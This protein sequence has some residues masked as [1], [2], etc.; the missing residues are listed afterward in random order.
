MI[1]DSKKHESCRICNSNLLIKYLDLGSTPLANAIVKKEDLSKNE[2]TFPLE[3]VFC[4]KCFL[5][6]LSVVVNPKIMFKEYPYRSS[7]S[8]TFIEHC[9]EIAD[10]CY[11]SYE[12]KGKDLIVDI[13]SND[14]CLLQQFKSKG[15]QVIGVDPATNLAEIATNRGI[16]TINAFWSR[17]VAENIVQENGHAKIIT[18]MNVFAHVND[19]NE[20]VSGVNILLEKEGIFIIEAPH[21]F[22]LIT[23]TEF[24]TIY[25][26]HL[27]YLLIKPLETLFEKYHMN[28]FRVE[29]TPIH[30]GSIRVYVS[31]KNSKHIRDETV[32]AIIGKEQAENLYNINGYEN[33]SKRVENIKR[34]MIDI[35]NKIKIEDKTVA[36]YGASAKGNTL[37]NYCKISSDMIRFIA[38]DTPEKQNHYTP[39]SHIPILKSEQIATQKPDY[40]LLLAWN[41]AKELMKKT[42]DYEKKG[43]KYIIPIP[44]VKVVT[45][46]N[47]ENH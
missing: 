33:F 31:H 9:K 43:G 34:D 46:R 35:L 42:E 15:S 25:H 19:L 17:T 5:S 11:E 18:A 13:A 24:D 29:E 6:Q 1:D 37:L 27:S 22:Q 36:A 32:D 38:D 7:I 45:S 40:L 28:I 2:K 8:K 44:E 41:F 12:I 47:Q 26:E 20:F 16:K 21:A 3:V 14:G 30:G 4:P 39:G 10:K 23:K